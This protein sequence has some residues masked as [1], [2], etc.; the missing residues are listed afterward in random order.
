MLRFLSS[1]CYW[2]LNDLYIN[3]F[4][5]KGKCIMFFGQFYLILYSVHR[6]INYF[7]NY[8]PINIITW[9]IVSAKVYKGFLITIIIITSHMLA[10]HLYILIQPHGWEMDSNM[11]MKESAL[12]AIVFKRQQQYRLLEYPQ[13]DCIW[14]AAVTGQQTIFHSA[15]LI[16]WL[17]FAE[18]WG[19][20]RV[21]HSSILVWFS[22]NWQNFESCMACHLFKTW[23]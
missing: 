2:Y 13:N 1:P 20:S 17:T 8:L 9:C 16:F 23:C 14:L 12:L 10:T 22:R 15:P 21:T 18:S 11:W 19:S 5:F 3:S 6:F 4:P 7:C